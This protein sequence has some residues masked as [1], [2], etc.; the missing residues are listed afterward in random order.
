M[1]TV[2]WTFRNDHTWTQSFEDEDKATDF[3]N[4][5][6]LVSHPDIESILVKREAGVDI[7]LKKGVAF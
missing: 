2:S 3:V 7:C 5:V 1:V 6:G 4:R